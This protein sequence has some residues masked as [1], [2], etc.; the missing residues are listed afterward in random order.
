M[1]PEQ[2]LYPTA[3]PGGLFAQDQ[4]PRLSFFNLE[5]GGALAALLPMLLQQLMGQAGMMPMQ[6]RPQAGAFEQMQALQF[7]NARQLAIA[8]SAPPDQQNIEL[9]IEK[10]ATRLFGEDEEKARHRADVIGEDLR[11]FLP[12]L[13]QMFPQLMS[14]VGGSQGS[15]MVAAQ[16]FQLA[17]R[18]MV[19]PSTGRLGFSGQASA[20]FAADVT[21]MLYGERGGEIAMR[22]IPVDQAAGFLAA[23]TRRGMGPRGIQ[24]QLGQEGVE[25]VT[26]MFQTGRVTEEGVAAGQQ[27]S[28]D[29]LELLEQSGDDMERTLRKF[30]ASRTAKWMRDMAGVM[31]A[32]EDIFGPGMPADQMI[33]AMNRLTQHNAANLSPEQLEMNLRVTRQ[34]A[35]ASDL[36]IAGMQQLMG[37]GAMLA[38]QLGLRR[39]AAVQTAQGAAAF[40]MAFDQQGLGQF[41]FDKERFTVHDQQL[42]MQAM[43]SPVAGQ[44]ATTLRLGEAAPFKAG[45]EAEA[46]FEALQAGRT[47]YT[48]PTT[49][50][51]KNVYLDEQEWRR[52]MV[53]GGV[54]DQ[55]AIQM[56]SQQALNRERAEEAGMEGLVRSMQFELDVI[57]DLASAVDNSLFMQ[58]EKTGQGIDRQTSQRIGM[59]VVERLRERGLETI[60]DPEMR[61]EAIQEV[62]GD[63]LQAAGVKVE[64]LAP[65]QLARMA[66]TLAGEMEIQAR[67][68]GHRNL[69]QAYALHDEEMLRQTRIQETRQRYE[70]RLGRAMSGLG[71]EEPLRRLFQ[72]IRDAGPDET[73]EGLIGKVF[74]GVER[75]EVIEE[76]TPLFE[77]LT[78]ERE[79]Y[80]AVLARPGAVDEETGQLTADA[81]EEVDQILGRINDIVRGSDQ[82]GRVAQG[83]AAVRGFEGEHALTDMLQAEGH[84][85]LSGAQR[86]QAGVLLQQAARELQTRGR[87]AGL[88][89][90]AERLG[91]SVEQL[92]GEA[93]L[94]QDALTNEAIAQES[95]LLAARK[96]GLAGTREELMEGLEQGE[97]R[98]PEAAEAAPADGDAMGGDR[99]F[100]QLAAM[101]PAERVEKI[102]PGGK[103]SLKA[104]SNLIRLTDK[105]TPEQLAH[106]L[107]GLPEEQVQQLLEGVQE[108]EGG[109]FGFDR[110]TVD[111]VEEAVDLYQQAQDGQ[112]G[113]AVRQQHDFG[114][115]AASQA[116][117]AAG[118]RERTEEAE[119]TGK[120]RV[121][122]IAGTMTIPGLGTG[123][124]EGRATSGQYGLNPMT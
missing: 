42:R 30:D 84:E 2:Y 69:A 17:G 111:K 70:A 20:D 75:E 110:E 11:P 12:F 63:E 92:T 86:A 50:A 99:E 54:D 31:R 41:G 13:A 120:D 64:E 62:L 79:A 55:V 58:L 4:T 106:L 102:M 21:R 67:A 118:A 25:A 101:S 95:R 48:D 6:F 35:E 85:A 72:A 36:G 89:A 59:Q 100:R 93:P 43:A 87:T 65:G 121:L 52:V 98:P 88:R 9:I 23:A 103:P 97:E 38:D 124:V 7:E 80:E 73:V 44:M 8:Q 104:R 109:M 40:S 47:T 57:P 122:K 33:T 82:L 14:A 49:G 78:A 61:R 53:A 46:L 56:R 28:A 29:E 66:T 5:Q 105:Y 22:G 119:L 19:D 77:E 15:T 24:A 34:L 26:Q 16:Q 81:K 76:L 51:S 45:S 39:S 114:T 91:V 123:E 112:D 60:T 116:E 18:H 83:L 90:M 1:P 10:V 27:L 108:H 71:R 74:G 115:V 117:Q 107:Q 37:Q 32:L 113:V 96:L 68:M 94:P 3:D